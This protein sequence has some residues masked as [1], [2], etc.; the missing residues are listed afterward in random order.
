MGVADVDAV[1]VWVL[2]CA[3]GKT[4]GIDMLSRGGRV[5]GI[6]LDGAGAGVAVAIVGDVAVVVGVGAT[7]GAGW[8]VVIGDSVWGRGVGS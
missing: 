3:L 4:G 7:V 1:L 8:G 2:A 5:S 6:G